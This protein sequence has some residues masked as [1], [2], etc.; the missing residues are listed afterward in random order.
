MYANSPDIKVL[1][2]SKARR[3]YLIYVRAGSNPRPCLFAGLPPSR[4]FDV[5]VN[6]YE[7]P[8][9]DD[10]LQANAEHSVAGGL[11]KFQ[12]AK[13]CGH[14][15]L[16][17]GYEGVYFLDEDIELQF[18]PS[19]FFEYCSAQQFSLAQAALSHESDGAWRITFRHPAFEFRITN[20]VEVMAP[21]FHSNFLWT[22]LETFDASISTYGLDVLWA[23]ELEAN[24]TAAIVDK[25][26][27]RHLKRRNFTEGR[28]Y[29]YL[30]TIGVNCFEEMAAI[31]TSLGI[32]SYQL[33]IKGGMQII[34]EVRVTLRRDS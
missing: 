33:Q 14:A 7:K 18:D 19:V 21:Y 27:M 23:S 16:F 31:L 8:H 32:E 2:T 25:F 5:A 28:F 34:E 29:E 12:A 6:Y 11:S 4:N 10:A 26:E 22:V 15:G 13:K 24:Q 9:C 17:D 30:K 1:R 3:P 20:F